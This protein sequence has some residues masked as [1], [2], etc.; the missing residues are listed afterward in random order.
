MSWLGS[1]AGSWAAVEADVPAPGVGECGNTAGEC[2]WTVRRA[3]PEARAE[4]LTGDWAFG[5]V[6]GFACF[7]ADFER[8]SKCRCTEFFLM[9]SESARVCLWLR[10]TSAEEWLW[11]VLGGPFTR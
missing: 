6:V 2:I 3:L 10:S 9:R 8:E 1:A 11:E 5:V 7:L 4:I